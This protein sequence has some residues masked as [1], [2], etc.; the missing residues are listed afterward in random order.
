MIAT[1]GVVGF[2]TCAAI[3]FEAGV[4]LAERKEVRF[5]LFDDSFLDALGIEVEIIVS[6]ADVIVGVGKAFAVGGAS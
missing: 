1:D 3:E 4:V 2:A 5:F 6:V